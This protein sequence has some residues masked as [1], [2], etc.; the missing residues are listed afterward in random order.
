M[1]WDAG[2]WTTGS[3]GTPDATSELAEVAGEGGSEMS[4]RYPQSHEPVEREPVPVEPDRGS[5]TGYA[6]IKYT[7]I[8]LIVLAILGF[9]AWFVLPRVG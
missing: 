5:L 4:E 9:L 6:A 8:L 7:A 1:P 3:R 2:V